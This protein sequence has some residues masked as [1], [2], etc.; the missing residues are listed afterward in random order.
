MLPGR[1]ERYIRN[2]FLKVVCF[3]C[4]EVK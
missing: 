1:A 2:I 3:N 4:V